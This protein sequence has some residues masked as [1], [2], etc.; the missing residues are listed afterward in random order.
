[1]IF[2]DYSNHLRREQRICSQIV[3]QIVIQNHPNI[4]LA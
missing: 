2:A 3:R 1:M 4:Q